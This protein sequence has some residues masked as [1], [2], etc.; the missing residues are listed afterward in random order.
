MINN[1]RKIEIKSEKLVKLIPRNS[2][3]LSEVEERSGKEKK[4]ILIRCK[5]RYNKDIIIKTKLA[6]L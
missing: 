2:A 5:I 3:D 4:F 6:L 1:R